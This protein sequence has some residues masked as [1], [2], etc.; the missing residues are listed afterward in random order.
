[1]QKDYKHIKLAQRDTHDEMHNDG[2]WHYRVWEP[3][4]S[5]L[6]H[7]PNWLRMFFFPTI[8]YVESMRG[9]HTCVPWGPIFLIIR[10][11]SQS[12]RMQKHPERWADESEQIASWPSSPPVCTHNQYITISSQQTHCCQLI[13]FQWAEICW[14]MWNT[15]TLFTCLPRRKVGS[16]VSF[17]WLRPSVADHRAAERTAMDEPWPSDRHAAKHPGIRCC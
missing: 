7:L 10:L 12:P 17:G 5:H 1:M 15:V 8:F 9:L 2:K 6:L 13:N 4:I 16:L 14:Q 11:C 3:E